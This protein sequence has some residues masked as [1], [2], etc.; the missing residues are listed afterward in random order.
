MKLS[1][2]LLAGVAALA[3]V[4]CGKK[5]KDADAPKSESSQLAAK[6][7]AGSPLDARFSLKG[8]EPVE[9]DA[10]LALIPEGKRPTFET[11]KFDSALGATIVENLRFADAND[12]EAVVVAR[13]EFYGVD[14]DAIERVRGADKAGP[15]APF[16]TVFQKVRFLDVASEGLAEEAESAKLTIA[17]VEFDKLEIRQGGVAGDGVGEEGARFFNAVNLAGLY[18]KN[19]V[20]ETHS[21]DA[22]TVAVKAPDLRFVGIGGGK[23]SAIIAN[24]F[25]Y[26]V[27]HSP[28]S[29]AAMRESMG[30]QGAMFLSGPL[31]GF[32]APE[33]QRVSVEALEWRNIDFAGLLAWG[34]KGEKPPATE[35]NLIDLGTMK[36]VKMETFVNGKLAAKVAEA[37]VSAADFTWMIPSNI[38]AETKG[39][40]YDFTA[41]VPATQEDALKTLKDHGL[42][43]V[44]GD[45]AAGWVWNDKSGA[46][47]FNYAVN[48]EKL[49]NINAAFGFGDLKLDEIAAAL[50]AGETDVFVSKGAFKGLSL[51]IKD[52]KALDAVFALAALQMGGT[53]EDLRL[54]VP[55]MIRLSGAQAAQMNPRISGYVNALAE[56][57]A[58]G[59]T[60][61]IVA[62]PA[63]PVAFMALQ[64]TAA[65]APQTLPDVIDLK[66]TQKP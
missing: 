46:A 1:N 17:G 62:A 19:L 48:M 5:N 57:V 8:A 22:P 45:G 60:L 23:L 42:D 25:G 31:A 52:E 54:S 15:D 30:P 49:V 63:E 58:K 51:K 12:G 21:T 20:L 53:G 11:A 61:E 43:K 65:T 29:H 10:L 27:K 50:D 35:K 40:V 24:D 18:F 3:L 66:V 38:R 34:V 7:E 59:G 47:D 56:F 44:K 2:I 64:S 39:A 4:A 6:A 28:E 33:S 37:T 14:M 36:A 41:Y 32:V 9:I 55:A 13:A 16:E 26:D